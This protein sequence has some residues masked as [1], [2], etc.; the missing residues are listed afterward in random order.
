MG[1]LIKISGF[2]SDDNLLLS[3]W[4]FTWRREASDTVDAVEEEALAPHLSVLHTITTERVHL[5]GF[6]LLGAH[7]THVLLLRL[8]QEEEKKTGVFVY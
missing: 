8:R 7:L 3:C 6:G 2:S 1:D 4:S 5:Q